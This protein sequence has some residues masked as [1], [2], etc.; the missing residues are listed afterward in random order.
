MLSTRK[1]YGLYLLVALLA[2]LIVIVATSTGRQR[3]V[4]VT[5]LG[6]VA[7]VGGL[8]LVLLT[9]VSVWWRTL[10][11]GGRVALI[12]FMI[13]LPTVAACAWLL[14]L[15]QS[16]RAASDTAQNHAVKSF[17]TNIRDTLAPANAPKLSIGNREER[18]R[19][20]ASSP[21]TGSTQLADTQHEMKAFATKALALRD[22]LNEVST[23][24]DWDSILDPSRLA[25]D[26]EMTQSVVMVDAMGSA[27]R[28]YVNEMRELIEGLPSD[29][30]AATKPDVRRLMFKALDLQQQETA[31]VIEVVNFLKQIKGQWTVGRKHM[32]FQKQSDSDKYNEYLHKIYLTDSSLQAVEAER[33]ALANSDL[34]RMKPLSK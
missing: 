19:A 32:L 13:A 10:K 28:T 29:I 27:M 15:S 7:Y 17:V 31:Q 5:A 26:K 14:F 33:L 24:T 18:F 1:K 22:Q 3:S 30:S 8:W 20:Y 4:L 9:A 21:T 23:R 11:D 2:V 16:Q 6:T 12:T 34:D 25:N